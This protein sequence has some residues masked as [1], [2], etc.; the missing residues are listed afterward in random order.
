MQQEMS[1]FGI[2]LIGQILAL[3]LSLSIYT[4]NIPGL[5]RSLVNVFYH[6]ISGTFSYNSCEDSSVLLNRK[7]GMGYHMSDCWEC[8]TTA[9]SLVSSSVAFILTA[10]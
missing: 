10:G 4:H 3:S 5:V 1:S 6:S 8:H 7:D 9:Q 2:L